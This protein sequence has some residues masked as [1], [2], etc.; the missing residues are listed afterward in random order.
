MTRAPCQSKVS[1]TTGGANCSERSFPFGKRGARQ[2]KKDESL[3][4]DEGQTSL[5]SCGR[6][7]PVRADSA[8]DHEIEIALPRPGG[9]GGGGGVGGAPEELE[10]AARAVLFS[11][12]FRGLKEVFFSFLSPPF[13]FFPQLRLA[14]SD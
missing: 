11:E 8:T 13:S 1:P 6:Q 7:N 2:P 3:S 10:P 4:E 14:D 12:A 5:L 9:K